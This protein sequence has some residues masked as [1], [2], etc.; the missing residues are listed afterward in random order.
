MVVSSSII[1]RYYKRLWPLSVTGR[2]R[3][4]KASENKS[5]NTVLPMPLTS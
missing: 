5:G 2:E 3:E 4:I 1:V